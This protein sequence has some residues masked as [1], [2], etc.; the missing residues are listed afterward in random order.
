[1]KSD[2]L[3]K[4]LAVL[5]L[6]AVFLLSFH[7]HDDTGIHHDCPIY[8]LKSDLVSS[9]IPQISLLGE[10]EFFA[11]PIIALPTSYHPAFLH[12]GYTSRAPPVLS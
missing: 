2:F 12:R 1:M 8:L 7:H 10:L 11:Q 9:D 5:L 4:Y 3:K 6:A